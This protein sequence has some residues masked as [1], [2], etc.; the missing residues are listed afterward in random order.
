MPHLNFGNT[1]DEDIGRGSRAPAGKHICEVIECKSKVTSSGSEY[2]NMTLKV[3]EGEY[4]GEIAGFD[5]IF[6]HTDGVL[7]RAMFIL[8]RLGFDVDAGEL[9]VEAEDLE[10]RFVVV[11]T[12]N[13]PKCPL[14]SWGVKKSEEDARRFIC[15]NGH[16]TW[17]GVAEEAAMLPE[18]KYNGYEAYNGAP[19]TPSESP[20][21]FSY[22]ANAKEGEKAGAG[23][24]E[25]KPATGSEKKDAADIAF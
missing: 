8:R 2:F 20:G 4:A 5:K 11:T 18:V 24:G 17:T 19:L 22:G 6:F 25:K 1:S 12:A 21:D 16:C 13:Q 23:G 14:C 3:V 7:K 9:D 10:H 15:E